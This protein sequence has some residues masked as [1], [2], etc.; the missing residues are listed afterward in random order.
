[1]TFISEILLALFLL[2]ALRLAGASRLKHCIAVT[3]CQGTVTAL[4]PLFVHNWAE[5]SH[6]TN[7]QMI[8]LALLTL[9]VK[10]F[11]LPALLVRAMHTAQVKRELEPLV[12]YPVSI[13][14][15]VLFACGAFTLCV[16]YPVAPAGTS[17][18]AAPSALIAIF[19]GLFII[20]ARKKAITQS[21]GFL[22]F[23][24]GITLFGACMKLEYGFLVEFGILLDVFV[25]VFVMGIA[26]FH[27]S[28]EFEHIDADRLHLLGDTMEPAK[29][30]ETAK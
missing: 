13:L 9:G 25:L 16:K 20:V 12:S 14:L 8:L 10:G 21:I 28:R 17:V 29:Q 24:N 7:M 23:E 19:T 30:G 22:F 3:A 2:A 11:L 26:V 6:D 4:Y 18:L 15:V 5:V 27:I 1:M